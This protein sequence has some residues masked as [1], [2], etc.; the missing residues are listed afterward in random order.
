[1]IDSSNLLHLV[2]PL[3]FGMVLRKF[4]KNS[5]RRRAPIIPAMAEPIKVSE[6]PIA[7]FVLAPSKPPNVIAG[8]K[9]AK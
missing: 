8:D 4:K 7:L 1:M 9:I 6:T 2:K 5:P 3:I